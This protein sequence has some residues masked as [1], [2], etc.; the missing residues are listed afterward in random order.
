KYGYLEVRDH[1]VTKSE[2]N[3]TYYTHYSL[4]LATKLRY[5][6]FNLTIDENL[7]EH[8]SDV[9]VKIGRE[10]LSANQ[11]AD[12]SY[13]IEHSDVLST[14]LIGVNQQFDIKILLNDKVQNL[15]EDVYTAD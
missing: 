8:I 4:N 6:S 3:L 12:G 10:W 1:D 5:S 15:E 9:K 7:K 11:L 13:T 2:V 14:A